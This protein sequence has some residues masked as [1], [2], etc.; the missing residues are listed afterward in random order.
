MRRRTITLEQPA[1]R[2]RRRAIGDVHTRE[3]HLMPSVREPDGK[4]G[5]VSSRCRMG[6]RAHRSP[7]S[8]RWRASSP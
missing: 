8:R 3:A 6:E 5:A 7:G 2:V 4:V 1:S